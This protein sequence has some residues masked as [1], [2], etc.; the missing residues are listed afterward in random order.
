[1]ADRTIPA[2]KVLRGSVGVGTTLPSSTFH[3]YSDSSTNTIINLQGGSATNKGAYMNF[4]RGT[5]N[6]GAFGTKASLIGGTSNDM[7][8]YS[9][10]N[11]WIFYST[12]ERMRVQ[13]DGLVGIGTNAPATLLHLEG[14]A[15]KLRMKE[16]GAETWDL[17]AAGS[18]WAVMMDGAD[19]LTIA[20][21]GSVGIGT[22][23][24]GSNTPLHIY[25]NSASDQTILLDNDDSGQTGITLRTD[26]SSDGNAHHFLYFEAPDSAGNNTRFAKIRSFV[27]DNTSGT[28]DGALRFSVMAAGSDVESMTIA[29][30]SGTSE[31]GW[32]GVGTNA[33]NFPLQVLGVSQTNGDAKRVVCIL[34]STSAAAG[35]GAGIAL[36]GYTNGTSSTINDFGIIQGI[37]ENSTA[38]DYASAMLFST[39]ANGANPAEQMRITSAGLL[40][41]GGNSTQAQV[42][43]QSSVSGNYLYM[44]D[45]SSVLF[46]ISANGSTSGVIQTQGTGFS[47]WK[48]MELRANYL[49]F[50]P[51]NSEMMRVLSTGVGI[52]TT[53]PS[54]TLQVGS[55][56][57]SSTTA[58]SLV[59]LTSATASSTVNGFSTLKLDYKSGHAPSTVGAQIM[60]N[61]GYH[62]GNQ[63]YTAPVGSIRGWKTGASD[64]YGGGLQFLYQPD[65]GS[66][67][68]LVGMTLEGSSNVG[69][70]TDNP[71]GKLDVGGDIDAFGF[72]GRARIGYLGHADIAGFC[73]RDMASTVNYALIQTAGG[74]TYVNAASGQQVSFRIANADTMY[75]SNTA[76]QFNDNKKVI[77]GNDSDL[78]LFHDGSN[79]YIQNG[80]TGSLNVTL[81]AGGEFAAR[82]VRDA[83]VELYYNGSKKIETVS[84]GVKVT[85]VVRA[86]VLNNAADSANIIYRSGSST[87]V[88]SNA[89]ALVVLDG[90]SVGLGTV[91]P[92]SLLHLYSSAPVLTIQDGGTHGT[93][94][95]PY[96]ELKDGSSTMQLIGA[97]S[98]AGHLDIKQKKAASVRLW[99]NDTER[100]TI[101]SNGTVTQAGGAYEWY[102]GSGAKVGEISTIAGNNLTISGTQT[103]HCG[104]S[105]ATNAILPA[106]QSATNNNTVDLGA[107]GNAFKDFYI[108]GTAYVRNSGGYNLL[109]GK[110]TGWGYAPN[111]YR[112]IQIGDASGNITVSIGYD[113]AGNTSSAFTGD[114]TELLFR[115]DFSFVTPNAANNGWH[116]CMHFKDSN[117]GVNTT[118]PAYPL[119]VNGNAAFSNG[120]VVNIGTTGSNTGKLRLYNNDST[121]Y[122][123]DWISTGARAYQFLGSTS[124]SDYSTTFKNAGSGGHD[125]YIG[126]QLNVSNDALSTTKFWVSV[127]GVIQWGS[128]AAH[129]T[130]TW[131]TDKAIIGGIGTNNLSLVAEGTEVVNSTSSTWD[132]KKEAKFPNNIGLFFRNAANSSTLGLKADTGDRITFRTGGAWDQMILDGNG[133]LTLAGLLGVNVAADSA[134]ALTIKSTADGTNVLSMKD[135]AGDAMFNIRQSSN[136][137]LIRGYKDGGTQTLQFHSDGES[138][139]K[140]GA[141][142][143]TDLS[144]GGP[145]V[146]SHGTLVFNN[147]GGSAIGKIRT[148]GSD[149]A[150]YLSKIAGSGKFYITSD[151]EPIVLTGGSVGI[152]T[153]SPARALDVDGR[154]RADTYGFRSDT[155]LRYYYFDD[156]S[157]SNFMGR[158]GNAFTSLYDGGTLSMVWKAGSV[159]IGTNDPTQPLVVAKSNAGG[160]GGSIRIDN[161]AGGAADKMQ[162]IFS[163]FGNSHHRA[164]IQSTVESSA[165]YAGTLEF[166]TGITS[167]TFTE[168][169][170]VDHNGYVGIGTNAP[171]SLLH[172]TGDLGNSA[173][174]AYF[175]NSGTQSEDNGLNVQI[176]SSGSSAQALRVNTGGDSNAFIVA[177]DGDVGVGFTPNSF[178]QKFNV[179][180]NTYLSGS[181]GIGDSTPSYKLDVSGTG[182]FTNDV[183]IAGNVGINGTTP[184]SS[185]GLQVGGNALVSGS[186]SA[187]SKSFLI[188]HPTKENKKLEY[189]CLEG[190]E[191]G[192]YHRGR[193][194]STT[195]SLPDYW[196]GLVR[197]ETITVQLTPKGSFQHLYVVSQ[198]LTEIVIGAA[199]GETI[200]C[201]YTIYGE[202]A[203]IDRLEVEKEV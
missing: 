136:D 193:A 152:G 96:I 175:Y 9:A 108:Q 51:N 154:V 134:D 203:D 6:V 13:A 28:E 88:G 44:D 123:V 54:A 122:Y 112:A 197:E 52:A 105:F 168:K 62:S 106:T 25:T 153:A 127:D 171:S 156:F 34:D 33:P 76:L 92:A 143:G 50:K 19:K 200:D 21:D 173:F 47:S 24:P 182:R 137:C 64:N 195:I 38:G 31:I 14:S 179:N 83:A 135:S 23:A 161:S 151:G 18:R 39:R 43:I 98:T 32:V 102:D 176:A 84:N 130:L 144:L 125:V 41:V 30:K 59:H 159:G 107:S 35:T 86:D 29:A 22:A 40:S 185:Y 7:M 68:L 101:A 192:V 17:Y 73:H 196:T 147:G 109:W 184:S 103:N 126:G 90:G 74:H 26:R 138:Y 124:G 121:A 91:A 188:N 36:G 71:A 172:V 55:V 167:G 97:T 178:A 117:I 77:L 78:Q 128:G 75:M 67:G 110:G 148:E 20:D 27:V 49:Q 61:Q 118:A 132:F 57:D 189:G 87:I 115:N 157:G 131:D 120:S 133:S 163:S 100:L 183:T 187:S 113:P 72:I 146:T 82:F 1:M 70:G 170:R 66:L 2:F 181:V 5:T 180:G 166:Y 79:S 190:P 111:S 155:S 194:Q 198:S 165:P 199:D 42:N 65:S 85:G 141:G 56:T 114:G 15:V 158:G 139:I 150:F 202:R 48:P 191:F 99:T 140:G 89:S 53:N 119:H 46:S 12:G 11:D 8:L 142:G 3:V 164:M 37:K 93:N 16:T 58:A 129:G 145:G 4:F 80:S 60:F 174:L 104:L 10:S 69:I 95:T 162:L 186:F 81:N 177:G 201:F 94:A 63:D 116:Y 169:M 160:I 45:G 149:D